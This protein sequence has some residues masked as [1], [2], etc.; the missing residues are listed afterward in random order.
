M[1]ETIVTAELITHML[2][3][4][5]DPY[6]RLSQWEEN[7]IMSVTDQW[8]SRHSLSAKQVET[9]ERIYAEKTA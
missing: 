9:L 7:F 8:E 4:L 5:E 3:C 1:A 2:K 6:K